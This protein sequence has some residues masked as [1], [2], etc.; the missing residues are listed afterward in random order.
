MAAADTRRTK[1]R[2]LSPSEH[3][4]QQPSK[5]KSTLTQNPVTSHDAHATVTTIV[6]S[7][8][9][10]SPEVPSV[11][12]LDSSE[13]ATRRATLKTIVEHLQSRSSAIPLTPTQCLQLWRGFFVAIYMH[14]SRSPLSVQNLLREIADTFT[15]VASK[16]SEIE[17]NDLT[18]EPSQNAWLEPYHT[19]FWET[20]SREW[21]TIDSHRMNKYLLLV[22]FVL[23]DLFKICMEGVFAVDDSSMKHSSTSKS[24]KSR[25][26]E[27]KEKRDEQKSMQKTEDCVNVLQTVGPLNPSQRKISDGLRL[28]VLDIWSDELF[29]ALTDLEETYKSNQ[30]TSTETEERVAR[31]VPMIHLLSG[32]VEAIAKSDS[33]AQRHIRARAKDAIKAVDAQL[34]ERSLEAPA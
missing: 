3:N 16:D 33:G 30:E 29:A 12:G 26:T 21:A 28:H 17:S 32:S 24:K 14:D 7:K 34:A 19:A 11:K 6:D 2:R 22:R 9:T 13:P 10:E 27:P 18:T 23:R 4:D 20:V 5:R 8:R 15:T 31:V 1:R 25:K